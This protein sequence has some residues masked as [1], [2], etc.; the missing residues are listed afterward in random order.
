M[1]ADQ[2]FLKL[3]LQTRLSI[4]PVALGI[5]CLFMSLFAVN[6]SLPVLQ[7]FY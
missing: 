1:S 5:I 6:Q 3:N 4:Q 7:R 2:I